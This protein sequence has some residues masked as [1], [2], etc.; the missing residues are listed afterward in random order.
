MKTV[1]KT[2]YRHGLVWA[3]SKQDNI[4]LFLP[5]AA[6]LSFISVPYS[7]AYKPVQSPR[8]P[9]MRNPKSMVVLL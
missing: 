3:D 1:L 2:G 5:N 6:A 9:I 8:N 4:V 7:R